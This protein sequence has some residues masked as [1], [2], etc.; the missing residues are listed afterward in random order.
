M[1]LEL[2]FGSSSRGAFAGQPHFVNAQLRQRGHV[3]PRRRSLDPPCVHL[4]ALFMAV[5]NRFFFVLAK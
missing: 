1:T 4:R 2:G 3:H 5:A